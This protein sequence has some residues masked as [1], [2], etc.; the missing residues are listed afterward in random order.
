[1]ALLMWVARVLGVRPVTTSKIT[2]YWLVLLRAA[3]A[4]AASGLAA[5]AVARSGGTVASR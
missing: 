3:K 2:A 4:L 1:M 5:S